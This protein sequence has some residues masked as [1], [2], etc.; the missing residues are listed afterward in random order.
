MTKSKPVN[1]PVKE[2][3]F[4]N[5]KVKNNPATMFRQKVPT[6]HEKK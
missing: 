5:K 1:K 2:G 4:A 6:K 3:K